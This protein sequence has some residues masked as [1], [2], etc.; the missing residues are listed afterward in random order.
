ML[1]S[2]MEEV[3]RRLS[4]FSIAGEEE[5]VRMDDVWLMKGRRRLGLA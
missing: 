4:G 1:W 5:V 2:I 3:L